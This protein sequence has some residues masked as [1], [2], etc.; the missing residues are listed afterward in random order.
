MKINFKLY[1]ITDRKQI[2]NIGLYAAVKKALD[3]GVKALQLREKDLD[4]RELLKQAYKMRELTN[5]YSRRCT[6]CNLIAVHDH[7]SSG[8]CPDCAA[9]KRLEE[10]QRKGN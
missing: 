5:K 4:T 7:S 9:D 3:G 8:I 10:N 6:V 2:V 1:L